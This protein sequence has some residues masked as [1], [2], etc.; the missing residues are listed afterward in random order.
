MLMGNKFD[1]DRVRRETALHADTL[2]GL[3][4]APVRSRLA[5][6]SFLYTRRYRVYA[7]FNTKDIIILIDASGNECSVFS[8]R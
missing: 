6:A 7:G 4:F 1:D 5:K 8:R 2:T 3:T